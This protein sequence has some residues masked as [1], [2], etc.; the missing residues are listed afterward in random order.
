MIEHLG[1]PNPSALQIHDWKDSWQD[2][3]EVEITSLH[4][5]KQV[6]REQ[7]IPELLYKFKYGDTE[8]YYEDAYSRVH[9]KA[10]VFFNEE[11]MVLFKIM[12]NS[13]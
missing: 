12:Y 8:T 7:E 1:T 5:A 6:I 9:Q 10:I 4:K 11:D 13:D 2:K 3:Y